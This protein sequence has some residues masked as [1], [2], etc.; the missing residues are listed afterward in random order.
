[1]H[2]KRLTSYAAPI[3]FAALVVTVGGW[4]TSAAD[5]QFNWRTYSYPEYGFTVMFPIEAPTITTI[6]GSG[7]PEHRWIVHPPGIVFQVN[8]AEAKQENHGLASV[9]A[10]CDAMRQKMMSVDGVV[11]VYRVFQTQSPACEIVYDTDYDETISVRLH[12]AG[13]RFYQTFV[14][15]PRGYDSSADAMRFQDSFGVLSP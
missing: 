2:F 7:T 14:R 3:I 9:G 8:A 1:M 13:S 10:I 11:R 15:G 6:L 12:I 4:A 5:E